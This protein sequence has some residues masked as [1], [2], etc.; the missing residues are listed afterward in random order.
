MPY[1]LLQEALGTIDNTLFSKQAMDYAY[2]NNVAIIASAADEDSFHHNMPGTNN[3][4]F[5]VHAI[6]YDSEG[7]WKNAKT[8][9]TEN[10]ELMVD[11]DQKI[12]VQ[13][14]AVLHDGEPLVDAD[15]EA[16]LDPDDM[17]ISLD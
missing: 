17:P 1:Q 11:I 10:P 15:D 6:T 14:G 8:F 16:E 5:Y 13:V 9:L 2:K 12:R 3:H 7:S 4:T